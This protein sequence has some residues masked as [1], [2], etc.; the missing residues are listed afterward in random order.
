MKNSFRT[1]S[2]LLLF[3]II[4]MLSFYSGCSAQGTT[5]L[6]SFQSDFVISASTNEIPFQSEPAIPDVFLSETPIETKSNVEV[7]EIPQIISDLEGKKSMGDDVSIDD[8]LII[9]RQTRTED[10]EDT[11]FV[12]ATGHNDKYRIIRSMKLSYGLYNEGWILDS[13]DEYPEGENR[14]EPLEGPDSITIDKYFENYNAAH[15]PYKTDPPYSSWQIEN[16]DVDFSLGAASVYV[17]AERELPLWETTEQLT[18][19]CLFDEAT[20]E[21]SVVAITE[22]NISL[23]FTILCSQEFYGIDDDPGAEIWGNLYVNYIDFNNKEISITGEY[24]Q[25]FDIYNQQGKLVD[26]SGVY[27]FSWYD[28]TRWNSYFTIDV[29]T[30]LDIEIIIYPDRIHIGNSAYSLYIF[31]ASY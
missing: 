6:P 24:Y 12:T 7:K 3:F 29:G 9:K 14:S 25:C 8:L 22:Q 1:T 13:V 28:I 2:Y 23:D 30:S 27:S 15:L 4:L 26:F 19:Q 31:N 20:C 17:T 16:E 11:V 21:W 18:F 10:L 5:E